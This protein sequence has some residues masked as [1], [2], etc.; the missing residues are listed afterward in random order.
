MTWTRAALCRMLMGLM[1]V[2]FA[3]CVAEEPIPGKCTGSNCEES[4]DSVRC[5]CPEI[6]QPVCGKDGKTY[7]NACEARCAKVPVTSKGECETEPTPPDPA[8]IC[9]S[10]YAPVCGK[11]GKTYG[12]ACEAA[13]AK[14]PVASDGEC[15]GQGCVCPA[16]YKPVC[17]EDGKTYGNSC[18]AGC[19]KVPVV[20]EGECPNGGPGAACMTNAQCP[21]GDICF[22]PTHQ[23]QPE[24]TINCLVYDP[25][26]GSDGK[27]YGC[28]KADAHCH[29]VEAVS[30]GEC[31]AGGGGCA[32]TKEYAPVCGADGTTYGNACMAK[33]AGVPVR[34][35][36]E[37]KPTPGTC[38][39]NGKLYKTGESFPDADG[40]NTC[41]CSADGLVACTLKACACDYSAPGRR[42]VSRSAEECT[43][44][45]F[46]C[47]AGEK[48]FFNNCGCG[49]EGG[50]LCDY[51][52]ADRTWAAKSPE[53]CKLVKFA[54]AAGKRPFF[55]NCGCGCEPDTTQC[56]VGGCSGQ[57][58]VGPGDPDISTCEWREAYACYKT[59]SCGVQADGRCGWTQTDELKKCLDAAGP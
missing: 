26:C 35:L 46:V 43:L 12:N 14:V 29:G 7:G 6:Y 5:A 54:C 1:A 56:K 9:P 33:C 50:P 28:G 4:D 13:C 51:N 38:M 34:H 15:G 48:H 59:A 44:I 16:I 25:V 30:P 10:I 31:P 3:A 36:G 41:S 53:Q 2:W 22:P 42:W 57:L 21:K 39:Y 49:C 37:C 23:C 19:A 32:C 58:C 27:T 47:Q 8:C 20:S 11:D 17:G 40:C 24:C 52:A 55:N 18:E 45:D